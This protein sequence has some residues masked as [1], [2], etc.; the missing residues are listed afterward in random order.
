MM[1]KPLHVLVG[2]TCLLGVVTKS[3]FFVAAQDSCDFDFGSFQRGES[4]GSSF[5]NRCGISDDFPC[6]CNPDLDGQVEC[7]YCGFATSTPNLLR[8]V[9]DGQTIKLIDLDG[10]GQSCTCDASDPTDPQPLCFE[11]E[12]ALVC[13]FEMEDGT[14]VTKQPGEET[15]LDSR[16]GDASKFPCFCNP[17]MDSQVECPY[18]S[19]ATNDEDTLLCLEEGESGSFI[20]ADGLGQECICE[21]GITP[22]FPANP[23]CQE[24]YIEDK[25]SCTYTIPAT[26]QTVTLGHLEV[27]TNVPVDGSEATCQCI[28]GTLDCGDASPIDNDD[29]A[30]TPLA[31]SPTPRPNP[32]PTPTAPVAEPTLQPI[33]QV[34]NNSGAAGATMTVSTVVAS[35]LIAVSLLG[36]YF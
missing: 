36:E 29:A 25:D 23:S 18:C 7:P 5:E 2:T 9:A 31:P 21:L 1:P 24:V 27:D 6:F 14:T 4:L 32:L 10:K 35:S 26:G 19:F 34:N 3:R 22:A 15:G 33:V 12:S 11:D 16:C 20:D 8:C 17:S 30:P 28:D 13:T